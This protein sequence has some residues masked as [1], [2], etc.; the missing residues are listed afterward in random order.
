MFNDFF[1][2]NSLFV[3]VFGVTFFG[4]IIYV[5]KYVLAFMKKTKQTQ[6]ATRQATKAL[7]YS[8]LY[9]Q[10]NRFIS[11][12]SITPN[13]YRNLHVLYICFVS[14][15]GDGLIID[16]FERVKNLDMRNGGDFDND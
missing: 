3:Q 9:N 2:L 12:G 13:E 14:M 4:A 7:L 16:L 6:M 15:G 5:I 10:C 8:S 1:N 11:R